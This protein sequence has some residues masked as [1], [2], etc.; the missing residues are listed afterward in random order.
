[1]CAAAIAGRLAAEALENAEAMAEAIAAAELT[2]G[3]VEL[4][5]EDDVGAGLVDRLE[6]SNFSFLIFSSTG[7]LGGDDLAT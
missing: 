7:L 2:A 1:M 6:N 4:G 3:E 5:G